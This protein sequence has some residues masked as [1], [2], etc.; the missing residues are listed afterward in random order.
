MA[1]SKVAFVRAGAE[2]WQPVEGGAVRVVTEED[3]FEI[4]WRDGTGGFVPLS[5]LRDALVNGDSR[6]VMRG[7]KMPKAAKLAPHEGE[8]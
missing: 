4:R 5:S 2:T 1:C 8:K 3:G 6:R 7:L